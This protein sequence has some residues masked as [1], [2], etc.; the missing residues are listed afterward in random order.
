[1]MSP[2]KPNTP[3][4]V[5]LLIGVPA[6]SAQGSHINLYAGR[7]PNGNRRVTIFSESAFSKNTP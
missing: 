3:L 5:I 6:V 4:A 1:M 7:L 2:L